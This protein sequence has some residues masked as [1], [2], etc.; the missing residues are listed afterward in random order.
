[1]SDATR[2][3]ATMRGWAIGAACGLDGVEFVAGLRHPPPSAMIS[4][5]RPQA[6][7][8]MAIVPPGAEAGDLRTAPP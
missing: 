4:R 8:L 5:V 7:R 2:S 3:P 6:Y 1:M